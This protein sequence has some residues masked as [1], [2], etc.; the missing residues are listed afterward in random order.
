MKKLLIIG[1]ATLLALT[2]CNKGSGGKFDEKLSYEEE[3]SEVETITLLGNIKKEFANLTKIEMSSEREENADHYELHVTGKGLTTLYADNYIYSESTTTNEETEDG[4]TVK[5]TVKST[6]ETADHAEGKAIVNYSVEDDEASYNVEKYTDET[7]DA[8]LESLYT[9]NYNTFLSILSNNTA[10]KGKSDF[11]FIAST[12]NKQV[13]AAQWGSDTK[14]KIVIQKNQFVCKVDKNY[15]ITSFYDYTEQIT[16]RD[17]NSGEWYKKEQTVLKANQSVKF[18][19]GKK[20]DA[21]SK[22]TN[23][24]NKFNSAYFQNIEFAAPS[25]IG[26]EPVS[27]KLSYEEK[28]VDLNKIHL[29]A[30]VTINTPKLGTVV[31]EPVVNASFMSSISAEKP[32]EESKKVVISTEDSLLKFEDEK[33]KVDYNKT[34]MK[35]VFDFDVSISG[36]SIELLNGKVYTL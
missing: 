10:Y 8:V 23:L 36:S 35:I 18:S 7:K 5:K 31:M 15:H 2:G 29:T 33:L 28:V 14:E 6:T 11:A 20:A 1:A 22:K 17:P 34:N 30:I 27:T 32:T 24:T 9:S 3:M 26:D 19:Y 16:N 21:G 13:T 25:K 12:Y 4:V